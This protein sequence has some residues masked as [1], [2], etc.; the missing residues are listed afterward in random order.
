LSMPLRP[1]WI[2]NFFSLLNI[3]PI[4]AMSIHLLMG[5]PLKKSRANAYRILFRDQVNFGKL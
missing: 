4:R 3:R 5:Y 1:T 2:S